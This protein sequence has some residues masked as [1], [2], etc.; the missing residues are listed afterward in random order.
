MRT[1]RDAAQ[2]AADLNVAGYS[3]VVLVVEESKSENDRLGE[4]QRRHDVRRHAGRSVGRIAR[5]QLW[6]GRVT[7]RAAAGRESRREARHHVAGKVGDGLHANLI[8]GVRREE[9][10]PGFL[11]VR[12]DGGVEARPLVRERVDRLAESNAPEAKVRRYAGPAVRRRHQRR[13]RRR[14]VAHPVAG[15]E[16][17][18]VVVGRWMVAVQVGQFSDLE[19]EVPEGRQRLSGRQSK[20]R[21]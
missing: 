4:V 8:G 6:L 1:D 3:A 16:R 13:G 17:R 9:V 7:A 14:Y 11:A 5:R 15:L 21:A 18:P 20:Q 12:T 10:A 19:L 2:V